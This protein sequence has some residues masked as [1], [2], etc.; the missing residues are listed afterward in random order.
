MLTNYTELLCSMMA[1]FEAGL[2]PKQREKSQELEQREK[3]Q[4]LEPL[5]RGQEE[6]ASV[7]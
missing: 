1:Y 2:Y 4:E 5:R 3:S 6:Q 7:D